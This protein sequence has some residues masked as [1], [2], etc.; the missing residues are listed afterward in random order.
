MKTVPCMYCKALIGFKLDPA[1]GLLR[2]DPKTEERH[3][4]N[5]E[6]GRYR[7]WLLKTWKAQDAAK[8]EGVIKAKARK[9]RKAKVVA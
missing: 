8:I 7:E 3:E 9:P 4:C 6:K 1:R 2:V 5:P